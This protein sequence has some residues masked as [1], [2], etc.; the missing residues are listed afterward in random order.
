MP[1]FRGISIFNFA[2]NSAERRKKF[3][4]E[5]FIAQFAISIEIRTKLSNSLKSLGT[6]RTNCLKDFVAKY[7]LKNAI[8]L[9]NI[10][11]ICAAKQNICEKLKQLR[12]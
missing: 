5:V 11:S 4:L 9:S 6:K 1:H 7:K 2:K 8:N 3:Q 10:C 12:I